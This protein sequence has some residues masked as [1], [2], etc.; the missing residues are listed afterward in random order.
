MCPDRYI[1]APFARAA[2]A[3]GIDAL[4]LEVHKNPKA[5]L[6]DGPNMICL[7]ELE[8]LLKELKEIDRI[9]KH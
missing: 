8:G 5:A 6:S 4:F 2:T 1:S 9:I 7:K 3:I